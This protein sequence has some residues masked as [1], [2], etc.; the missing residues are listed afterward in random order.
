M[1]NFTEKV[2]EELTAGNIGTNASCEWYPCHF[3]GQNCSLCFCPFYPC[4]DD[5]LGKM[6]E[7]KNGPVWSCQDCYW[8]HRHD[9]TADF[10]WE[11]KGRRLD[12]VSQQDLNDMKIKIGSHHFQKAKRLMVMGATSGAGKSL[13]CTPRSVAFSQ[14]GLFSGPVQGAEH[15]LELGRDRRG[16]GDSSGSGTPGTGRPGQTE[17]PHEPDPAEA[18]GR[19][20]ITGQSSK[21]TPTWTWMCSNTMGDSPTSKEWRSSGATSGCYQRRPIL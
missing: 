20:N 7:G 17:Q 9:V 6:V 12:D 14:Y 5:T 3:K 21:A 19:R 1:R 2:A 18:E 16:R 4:M 10:F 15:V 8:V 13:I 11:M